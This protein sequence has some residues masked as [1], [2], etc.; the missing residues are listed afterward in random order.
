MLWPV[1]VGHD[2]RTQAEGHFGHFISKNIFFAH[3]KCYIFYFNTP[4]INLIFDWAL[5]WPWALEFEHHWG[6]GAQVVR[7]TKC[8][9]YMGT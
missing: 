3:L 1:Y 2:P 4:Q 8:N 7:E 6:I 5:N 9:V